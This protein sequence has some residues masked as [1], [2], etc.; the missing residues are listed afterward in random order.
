MQNN[1]NSDILKKVSFLVG[2]EKSVEL[3]RLVHALPPFADSV[4]AFLD[5]LSKVLMKNRETREYS[6]VITFAFWIRK[7]S[8]LKLKARFAASDGMQRQG[9]GVVFHIT[10]SNVPINFAYSLVSGLLTGNA[11]VVRVPSKDFPQISIITNALILTLETHKDL[12]P[13]V[14][15]IRYGR[16]KSIND[17]FSYMADMRI[18]WGGNKTIAELRESPLAP[19]AGEISFADRYSLAV[20]DA[21]AY[22]AERDKEKIAEY[23]YND[24]FF[25]DQNACTSP[26]IVIW[27]GTCVD[28]ARNTFWKMEQAVA[29]Q[30]YHFQSMQGVDKLTNGYLI[31]TMLPGVKVLQSMDNLIVRIE[32]PE[33]TTDLMNYSGNSGFF[34]EYLCRDIEEIVP[35]CDDKRCQTIS[36]IGEKNMFI[37]LLEKRLKGID[38]IV[39]VGKSMDFDLIWD[40]YQLPSMLT[41]TIVMV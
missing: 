33:L 40:G 9:K 36:Y 7:A 12:E 29:A 26:R 31:A 37:P 6:D 2:T 28:E 1:F 5:D 24:T 25:S 4:I 17:M 20:I 19:R 13:Y 10:P 21:D 27:L 11:N 34:L 16:E 18:V 32:V 14:I 22:L 35:V 23:F 30:K 38:R 8:V 3:L 41:R 39:P 15:C